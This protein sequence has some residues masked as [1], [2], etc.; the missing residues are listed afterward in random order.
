MSRSAKVRAF[1]GAADYDF[2]LRIGE[3]EELQETLDCGL[4]MTL[5]RVTDID[6]SAIRPVLR[7]GL[8]GGGLGKEAA[9]RLVVRHVAPGYLVDVARVAGDV[10]RAAMLGAED[11]RLGEPA[12]ETAGDPTSP[13]AS[14]A[15][16]T[17][18]ASDKPSGSDP[19]TSPASLSGSSAP[20]SPVGAPR[21]R[22]A[23]K[24][25]RRP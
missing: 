22:R 1:F 14:S 23:H 21:M 18:T 16:P 6:V 24:T 13:G 8:I 17:F 9:F 5:Q 19:T 25:T 12:G 20:P 3:V 11:E 10:V 7:L 15:S 2:A 4:M